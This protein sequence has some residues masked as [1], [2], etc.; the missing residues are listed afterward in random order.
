MLS[1]GRITNLLKYMRKMRCTAHWHTHVLT[2]YL[3]EVSPASMSPIQTVRGADST[4]ALRK[5]VPRGLDLSVRG[6]ENRHASLKASR[7]W[8]ATVEAK[9][10]R[11]G[12]G[13]HLGL[14]SCKRLQ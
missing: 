4:M 11:T 3:Q 6:A 1:S 10:L 12:P 2:S 9:S 14:S 5:L 8:H 7:R 13:T